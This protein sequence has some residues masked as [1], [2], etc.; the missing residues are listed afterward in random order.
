MLSCHPDISTHSELWFLLPHIDAIRNQYSRSFYGATSLRDATKGL[1]QQLPKG[2]NDY[3]SAVRRLSDDIY[4][5]LAKGGER[6]VLDKT[7]RYYFVI[8]EI[9]KLY[10]DAKFIFLFRNPLAIAASLVESFNNGKLGDA[11]HRIDLFEGPKMLANGYAQMQNQSI[12]VKYEDLV[13]D[14]TQ[15]LTRICDYLELSYK[16]EMVS[17]FAQVPVGVMGDQFGSKQHTTVTVQSIDKWR[18]VFDTRYRKRYLEQLLNHIGPSAIHSFGYDY[19]K[20]QQDLNEMT[21]RRT[22]A[23]EDRYREAQCRVYSYFEVP[24]I[25]DKLRKRISSYHSKYILQ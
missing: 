15:W 16:H 10:P 25:K 14:P 22:L 11:H 4:N 6:Y 23:L 24:L 5:K 20:L 21:V 17:R 19:E 3:F 8:E 7:P 2:E 18:D 13:A 9:G 12:A 1:L